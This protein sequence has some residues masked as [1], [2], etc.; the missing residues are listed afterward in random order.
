M[1]DSSVFSSR[2]WC[3]ST[4]PLQALSDWVQTEQRREARLFRDTSIPAE[5]DFIFHSYFYFFLELLN[6]EQSE[7]QL[8]PKSNISPG[9]PPHQYM[10]PQM[11]LTFYYKNENNIY[12]ISNQIYQSFWTIYWYINVTVR[13]KPETRDSQRPKWKDRIRS[14]LVFPNKHISWKYEFFVVYCLT[15]PKAQCLHVGIECFNL[16]NDITSFFFVTRSRQNLH[17]IDNVWDWLWIAAT[18]CQLKYLNQTQAS[19][20][21]PTG[22]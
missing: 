20:S 16:I 3:W 10:P 18:D 1:I 5:M 8:H 19:Q 15:L 13:S 6:R 17:K 4:L 9:S 22:S 7:V 14:K 12:I 21:Q 11:G 2:G